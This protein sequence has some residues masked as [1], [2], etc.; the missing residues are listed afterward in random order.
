M[1]CHLNKAFSSLKYSIISRHLENISICC[2]TTSQRPFSTNNNI[3][4]HST[5]SIARTTDKLNRRKRRSIDSNNNSSTSD[6]NRINSKLTQQLKALEEMTKQVKQN[7]KVKKDEIIR[8]K[9][10]K[11]N[12]LNLNEGDKEKLND[13]DI[14]DVF[15]ALGLTESESEL[16]NSHLIEGSN[17]NLVNN[18]TKNNNDN[19]DNDTNNDNNQSI[20]LNN[21]KELM[22]LFPKPK[23]YV[24]LPDSINSI[25][26][27][28]IISNITQEENSNWE[29]VIDA[30]LTSNICDPTVPIDIMQSEFTGFD[31]HQLIV[32]IPKK[33][34]SL[35]VEK[36]HELALLSGVLWGNIHVMNDLLALCNLLPNEKS[37]ILVET[38]LKD[39][40][41]KSSSI[42]S[43]EN[44]EDTMIVANTTTKAILL[45]HYARL[46]NIDK[47]REY[48]NELNKLPSNKNPMNTSP[49]VY[50]S[51]LQMYMRLNNYELA[52]ETFDT[53][54]FLSMSTSPSSRTYT[55]MILLDTLN[56]NIEHGISVYEEMIEKEIKIEPDTL[57]ALA[58]GCGSRKGMIAKGWDFIIKYYENGFNVDSKVMEIMMYLAYVDGDLAFVRGIWMN[59][60][61]TNTKLKEEI[62]LPH[63]KCTK[64]LFNTYYK[65][66][67]IIENSKNG[68]NHIPIGMIDSRV[69]SIRK[70]VLELMNFEFHENAPPLLPIIEFDGSN[71]EMMLNE[72]RALWKYMIHNNGFNNNYISESLIEA[73]LYVVG[74]YAKLETFEKEWNRL[75]IFDNEGINENNIIIEEPSNENE[76]IIKENNTT[77]SIITSSNNEILP[78]DRIIRNDRLYNMCM[79]IARNQA[80]LSF[81]QKIW[82]E[83]GMY[84]KSSKFQKMSI[85]KQDEAD[86]KFAR[87]MLSVFTHLGNVGD[88]YK[89]V[90]SSQNRFMW[91][92]YHLKSLFML[93]E[94]LGYTTFS[95]EL[96]KVVKRSDKWSR[97]QRRHSGS[98]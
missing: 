7:I 65:I 93:C 91:T 29:P 27:P 12:S 19:N 87:L 74:R 43:I 47:V 33:Q 2:H 34:K 81:A 73:Y 42:Q 41:L 55:S 8:D 79:H 80:S 24:K 61:E 77:K 15:K 45:N 98:K 38:L 31:F 94:R 50:T 6:L 4:Y 72:T 90:L 40:D 70:K 56:N 71:S 13:K 68:Q 84:R 86:F 49:V 76:F 48:V 57:L 58:K 20:D 5:T 97:R 39:I 23:S 63:A 21:E 32:T 11:D 83:R 88:G 75:T 22:N 17:D 60:C 59:I 1:F 46:S 53:M 64:W 67:D 10:I 62:Q 66:G 69:R 54:K 89:L 78:F 95:K 35:I 85:I 92:N 44:N 96:F 26:S 9:V 51:I 30:L 37:K 16:E 25:L 82:T 14:D 28:E 3:I 36:L 18:T 52:K